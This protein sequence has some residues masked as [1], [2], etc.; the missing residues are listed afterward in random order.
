MLNEKKTKIVATIGPVSES[1]ENMSSLIKAGMNVARLNFSHGSYEEHKNRLIN[2][3]ALSKELKT[4]IAV[5]QDL[6]GPKIR[7]GDFST[8]SVILKEGEEFILTTEDLALGS[9]KIVSISY[10][11]LHTELKP[12]SIVFLNDGKLKLQVKEISGKKIH[13]KVIFGGEIKGRRGVNLPGAYLKINCL[14]EKDLKDVQWGIQNKVDFM[15]LSFVRRASDVEQLRAILKKNK[16]DIHIIAKIETQE[17]V[18]NLDEII[19]SADGIMVARGDLAVEIPSEQVP[20]IQKQIV[21]KCN[22][23]GKPVI[24]A[25]QMLGSMTSSSTPTRAEI[26]DVANA[27]LDGT[28]AVMLSEETTIGKHPEQAVK[29]MTR[30]ALHTEK[31]VPYEEILKY[32][33]LQAKDVTES[34][35]YAVVNSAHELN[36]KLIISLTISGFTS[37]MV[38]RFKPNRKILVLTPEKNTYNRLALSFNCYPILTEIFEGITNTLEVSKKLAVKEGFAKKD[39]LVIIAAGIPFSHSGKTN[40]LL[41]QVI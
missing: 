20:I 19:N 11:S 12:G 27:I 29:T 37:R 36:A 5:L 13:T 39:D 3:R 32:T 18:E 30:V 15:A 34:I 24:V 41:V 25:T 28:D 16:A 2:A 33:H 21:K 4:P 10:K 35:S 31:Y 40:M 14:T 23:L 6:S 9:D 38:A 17:A 7:I 1:K 22:L 8:E 26:N